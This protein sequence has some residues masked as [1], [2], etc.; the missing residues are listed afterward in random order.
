MPAFFTPTAYGTLVQ[1]G[2]MPIKYKPDGTIAIASKPREVGARTRGPVA[3]RSRRRADVVR[4]L[5]TREFN[6]RKYVMEEAIVGDF[7]LVKAWKADPYG[8]LVFRYV[9][10]AGTENGRKVKR[11]G[12]LGGVGARLGL[13]VGVGAGSG[14]GAVWG[15]AGLRPPFD[16]RVRRSA[17][18]APQG[19]GPQF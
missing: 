13:G 10:A 9:L 11:G 12:R 6:G 2:G 8:N 18:G 14:V 17:T 3:L 5:Q 19:V 7:S 15:W 4:A 1:T 16:R